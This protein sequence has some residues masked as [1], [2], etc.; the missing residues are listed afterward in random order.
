[1]QKALV[2]LALA[3]GLFESAV[4]QPGTWTL[5]PASPS[6][7]I[8]GRHEDMSWPTPERGYVVNFNGEFYRTNDGGENWTLM[9]TLQ[10]FNELPVR[11]RS[12]GFANENRGWIGT[13]TEGGY[14]LWQT[15]DGGVTLRNISN[16]LGGESV[17][18][19]GLWV[20][21]ENVVYGV[22]RYFG[23]ARLVMTKDGGLSW[24]VKNMDQWA[25]RLIDVF[26]F[27]ENH[28]FVVGG[29]N[30]TGPESKAVVIRTNDGGLTWETMH[31]SSLA[32][33]W[34][35]K[36]SFPTPRVGYVSLERFPIGAARV[37]RTADGGETW[38]EQEVVGSRPL[39]GIGFITPWQGWVSGRGTTYKTLNGGVTW[40]PDN[41][42]LDPVI[43]RFRFFGDTLAYALGNRVYKYVGST[44]V[45]SEDETL[46]EARN[47]LRPNYPNPFYPLTTFEYEVRE[48]ADVDITVYDVLGRP[49]KNLVNRMHDAGAHRTMWDG[50]DEAGRHVAPGFYLY[51]LH[52]GS[53]VETRR[54]VYLGSR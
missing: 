34:G 19:C 29:T 54:M 37:L 44:Q 15:D 24:T 8:N 3:L 13:L 17:G 38:T 16:R 12:V 33:E 11:F 46:P 45:S 2:I 27:D 1:M 5:L 32:G 23:P 36:I 21:N 42:E 28:G 6:G 50:T 10:T 43:N 53:Y 7:A 52:S 51:T 9:H 26:F 18:I 35:W 31:V 49:V 20:V 41:S 14:Q 47:L 4:A 30:E 25:Q 48:Q 39:Q 22:G 40:L